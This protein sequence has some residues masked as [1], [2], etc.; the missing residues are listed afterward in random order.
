MPPPVQPESNDKALPIDDSA[1]NAE[2]QADGSKAVGP[3]QVEFPSDL[4]VWA[5]A[6]RLVGDGNSRV[7]DLATCASQDPVI[8]MELLKISNA[9]YFSAG[10][11]PI[12]STRTAIQ[13]LGSEVVLKTLDKM[14]ERVQ[15]E[16]KEVSGWFEIHRSRCRRTAIIARVLA[17][18][19][20]KQ[21]ADECQVVGSF[22]YV[23]EMLA[24]IYLAEKYAMLADEMPRASLNYRL[25]QD[26]KFDVERMGIQYLR[27]N[28]IPE[29][30]LFA[31]DREGRSKSAERAVM[32][33]LC[34]AA[35]ELVEAFD[36]NKWDKFAPGKQ[37]PPK[38]AV[39]MLGLGESQYLKIYE[40]ISEY[41]FAARVTDEKKKRGGDAPPVSATSITVSA[42]SSPVNSTPTDQEALQS[43]IEDILQSTHDDLEPVK[44]EAAPK[45]EVETQQAAQPASKQEDDQFSLSQP[46]PKANPRR[47]GKTKIIAPP[48]LVNS[49]AEA[50]VSSIADVLN[51]ATNSEQ[52]LSE[53][54]AMLVDSGPFNKSAL[55]V[56]SKDRKKAIVVAARGPNIGNGQKLDLDDPLNPL[57]QCFSKVQSF[58]NKKSA[59]SPFGSRSFAV[60]PIDADHETPV[61]LYAD[62]GNEGAISF[63]ARR[64]FR[65]VVEILNEKLPDIPGGIPIEL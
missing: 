53:I 34:M 35:G 2:G 41:L 7:D 33:P 43:E 32:K 26:F 64:V 3:F 39:R 15:I 63:E 14:H 61:A 51:S 10:R 8:V 9:M 50:V 60:A 56:V 47:T 45:K 37:L 42:P 31:I 59:V 19:Q 57:A 52:L 12:T 1:K 22:L 36:S 18:S 23:G 27:R 11:Q 49:N 58:G 20:A 4:A 5:Q 24:A 6:R 29:A 62:C 40:R 46:K 54:L 65:T 17:E 13:R 28:G 25:S 55:I 30:L 38:S 16:N 48:K 21:L 44:M